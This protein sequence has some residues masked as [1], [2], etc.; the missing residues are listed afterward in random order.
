V[1]R[2]LVI[3]FTFYFFLTSTGIVL[4]KHSCGNKISYTA[5]GIPVGEAKGCK[6]K[7]KESPS[8]H[9]KNCCKSDTKWLKCASSDSKT[10]PSFEICKNTSI[11]LNSLFLSLFYLPV[12]TA[13][14]AYK[15]D[16]SPPLPDIPLFL[17]NRI[18]L[19]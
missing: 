11:P 10:Q 8:E 13:Y 18:L 15:I 1:K 3:L 9:K 6:C 2:G 4:G 17:K 7:H 16:H 12:N 5:W 14:Q 19:I